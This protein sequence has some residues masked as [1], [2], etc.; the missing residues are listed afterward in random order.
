MVESRPNAKQGFNLSSTRGTFVGRQ[1]EMGEL[2]A[3]LE[4]ARAG[5]GKLVM[6]VLDDLHWTDKS[7]LLLLQFLARQLSDSRLLV[8]GC[9]RD[10]ELSR[11][12][13]LSETLA[14]LTREP[15]FHRVLLRGLSQEDT[16]GFIAATAGM[17]PSQKLVE[18]V[19]T[20]TEGNPFFMTEV[21]RLLRGQGE[22]ETDAID[23][24]QDLRIPEGVREI[25]GQRLNRL[26][27]QCY[28]TLTAAAVI[29]REFD[30]ELL[31]IL[32]SKV[33]EEQLLEV[34]D[35]ALDA[36][37]IQGVPGGAERYQF[38]HAL[39]QQTLSEEL[40]PSRR[41]RMHARIGEALERL[42][43]AAIQGH[44]AELAYHFAEARR[45][46]G[47]EKLVR[48]SLL[49]GERALAAYAYE[50]AQ[51]QFQQGLEA[52]GVPLAGTE[53]AKDD[54]TAA[55]LF[56]LA[57]AEAPTGE[58]SQ[59]QR[60]LAN[61]SRAF[62]Y[63]IEVG[64]VDRAVAVAEYP[65]RSFI[66]FRIGDNG[67]VARALPLVPPESIQA[68]RLLAHYGWALGVED[69]DLDGANVALDKALAI[70]R[71]NRDLALEMRVLAHVA[72]VDY[73]HL[74]FQESLTNALA[75]IEPGPQVD[76]PRTAVGAYTN[77]SRC[78]RVLGDLEGAR[79]YAADTLTAAERLGNHGWLALAL[80]NNGNL[81]WQGGDS[82][83]ARNFSDRGLQ[84][85]PKHSSLLFNRA[86]L[87]YEAGEYGQ[88][89]AF[90]ERLSAV[91]RLETLDPTGAPH[92]YLSLLIPMVAR[93]TGAVDRLGTAETATATVLAL[94][95]PIRLFSM[96]ARAAL[97]LLA[98]VKSDDEAAGEQYT[99]LKSLQGTTMAATLAVDRLLGLLMQT[100]GQVDEAERH[101]EDALDF[102]RKG[103]HRP[104][105]AWACCDYADILLQRNASGDREKA[106]SLL[107]ESLSISRDLGMQP[108]MERV[109][110]RQE[111]VESQPEKGPTYPDGLTGREVEVLRL[112]ALGKSNR[113][114]SEELVIAEGTVRRHVNNTYFKIGATNRAEATRYALQKGLV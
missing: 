10:V 33:S 109:L 99:T 43:G 8:V 31:N 82:S 18:S 61:L 85:E 40:S 7:S 55:L 79:R 28:Q 4:D 38:S 3:A 17:Q 47:P 89:E 1:R 25:I 15:A 103:G 83:A 52:K 60:L 71:A 30:F 96:H 106:M 62:N 16:G 80:R 41:V 49:A 63:Y 9:Y 2:T 107:D 73:L 42:Y 86:L 23:G 51:H 77:A 97:G 95:K 87:E 24:L 27:D 12:H 112:I 104:E 45:T 19:H 35:E 110:S 22:I 90:L 36:H 102:C 108:L 94:P 54:E 74:R 70:A 37:L 101:F 93:I 6:L 91:C 64:D 5:H 98:V 53:P 105:L 14:Q 58:Q 78:L 66:G 69:G 100:V 44:A 13:I 39:I 72:D 26:S 32:N 113:E 46:L 50:E 21:I 92:A 57:R 11:Q 59:I 75:A 65:L 20:H 88:G 29:G 84:L 34:I 67:I 68:G 48:Y 56:G 114:I 76:D 111:Q 81:S